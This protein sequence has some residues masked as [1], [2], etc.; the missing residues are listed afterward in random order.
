MEKY[1]DTF[2]AFDRLVHSCFSKKIIGD[3]DKH[4]EEFKNTY[5]KLNLTIS[6]KIHVIICH[7]SQYLAHTKRGL[8]LDSEQS[9]ESCHHDFLGTYKKYAV[10]SLENSNCPDKLV[11]SVC[12][13]NGS[14]V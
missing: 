8:G 10:R 1:A 13:Y 14:H 2:E 6:S 3:P 9:L 7:L 5:L 4:I 11:R 12:D